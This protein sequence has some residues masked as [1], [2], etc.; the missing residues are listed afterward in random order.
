M[1]GEQLHGT[2]IAKEAACIGWKCPNHGW[3]PASVHP[4][5][6]FIFLHLF[7]HVKDSRILSIWSSLELAFQDILR[8]CYCPVENSG[9]A[10]S[11]ECS[12]D[13]N[14]T[15]IT[16][17][18][19]YCSLEGFVSSKTSRSGGNVAKQGCQSAFVNAANATLGPKAF[20][21]VDGAMVLWWASGSLLD[22]K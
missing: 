7:K 13:T 14:L 19:S 10:S 16:S 4:L 11:K 8:H 15:V 2:F 1:C 22:L 20:D 17:L 12:P 5:E 18:W 9:H 6:T 3:Q 21:Y